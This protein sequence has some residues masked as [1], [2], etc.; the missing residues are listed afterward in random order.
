MKKVK[1]LLA[2]ALC[3]TLC[4]GLAGC[5]KDQTVVSAGDYKAS[6][7]VYV[8]NQMNALSEVTTQEGYDSTLDPIWDNQI[9]G[10]S[11]EDW[12]NNRALDLTK[13]YVAVNKLFED[14]GL[15]LSEEEQTNITDSMENSFPL[16]EELYTQI[17]VADSSYEDYM[18]FNARYQELFLD[19]YQEG[20]E[21]AVSEEDLRSY[22]CDNFDEVKVLS[23]S[24][25]EPTETDGSDTTSSDTST[26]TSTDTQEEDTT[27]PEAVQANAQSY[28]DRIQNGENVDDVIYAYRQSTASDPSSVTRSESVDNITVIPAGGDNTTTY[29]D[30]VI[31]QM[32]E[33]AP[34]DSDL[35]QDSE[36]SRYYVVYKMDQDSNTEYY[37]ANRD[38]ILYEMK[39]EEFEQYL[40][41]YADNEMG[42]TVNG[43][44]QGRYSCKKVY[45]DQ[46]EFMNNLYSQY[47]GS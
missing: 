9:D 8:L 12:V 3:G 4:L 20:G 42:A 24:Y 11:M 17:G 43:M 23:F 47:Y 15:S 13:E 31:N 10:Q 7:A 35:I 28:L 32:V 39:N 22:Y 25:T 6:A 29:S 26:D 2:L 30:D 46:N 5:G 45:D 16:Y 41:D 33:I 14:K 37:D 34:G 36:N 19:R 40:I 1:S 38:N 27:S 44:I 18:V 21:A